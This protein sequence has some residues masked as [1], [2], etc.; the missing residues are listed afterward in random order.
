VFAYHVR[1]PERYGVVQFDTHGKAL[2]IE[3]KPRQ[4]KSNYAVTGLYFYDND[5]VTFPRAAASARGEYEITDVNQAYLQRGAL[6]VELMGRGIA[7][8]DTGTHESLLQARCS[9]RRSRTGRAEGMLPGRD[10]VSRR[11]Y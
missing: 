6:R 2:G 1:D 8:L 7:W 9:S 11:V 3:E 5:V 4:P 10:R